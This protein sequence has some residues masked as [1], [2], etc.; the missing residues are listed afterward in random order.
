MVGRHK[1]QQYRPTQLV[2]HSGTP[3][4]LYSSDAVEFLETE[5]LLF[6]VAF[7]AVVYVALLTF[8]AA[9]VFYK[10]H[11]TTTTRGALPSHIQHVLVPIHPK[12]LNSFF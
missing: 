6:G 8:V 9:W 3:F 4:F 10:R 7:G 1:I 5:D 2:S 11:L 12:R